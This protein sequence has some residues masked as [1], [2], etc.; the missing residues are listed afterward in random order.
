M[1]APIKQ[2]AENSALD[3]GVIIERILSSSE[4]NFGFDAYT[5]SYTNMI[6]SGIIDPALVTKSALM[7]ASSVA[8]TLLSTDVLIVDN[9]E[10]H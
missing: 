8:K 10:K 3:A 7:N 6:D 2:I 5:E 4:A 1:L 9:E